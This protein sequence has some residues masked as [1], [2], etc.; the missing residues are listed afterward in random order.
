MDQR[1]RM[2]VSEARAKLYELVEE[3]TDAPDQ[4]V[5]IEHRD[6]R[7]RAVLVDESHFQYLEAIATE[8]RKR[9]TP[10]RLRG[11][12]ELA[13]SEDEFDEWMDRNRSEQSRLSREKLVGILSAPDEGDGDD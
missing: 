10:F 11:S 1:K 2:T 12:L 7:S 8:Y 3:V 5:V 9:S 6:R 4:A 13:V